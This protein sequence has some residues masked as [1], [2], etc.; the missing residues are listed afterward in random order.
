MKCSESTRKFNKTFTM[1]MLRAMPEEKNKV[2]INALTRN[3]ILTS[4]WGLG[5]Q[6]VEVYK[7]GWY[8]NMEGCRCSFAMWVEDNDGEFVFGKR[9]PKN[10]HL[11][12]RYDPDIDFMHE[13]E[14]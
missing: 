10:I 2:L 13:F 5:N 1:D 12:Y 6:V 7:E 3:D 14:I 11:L 4:F 9:K 8:I